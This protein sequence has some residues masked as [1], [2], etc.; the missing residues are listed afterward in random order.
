MILDKALKYRNEGVRCGRSWDQ[1][2][3]QAD[4]V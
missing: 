3:L 1:G 4:R 2:A